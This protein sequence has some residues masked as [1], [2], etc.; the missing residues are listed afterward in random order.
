MVFR[1]GPHGQGYYQDLGADKGGTSGSAPVS[2]ASSERELDAA[3]VFALL[4]LSMQVAF[5][6]RDINAL[7]AALSAMPPEEAELCMSRCVSSG[8]WDPNGG[9]G[10][11]AGIEQEPSP[12]GESDE[13]RSC[14][15]SPGAAATSDSSPN[16]VEDEMQADVGAPKAR[17][18]AAESAVAAS[19]ANELFERGPYRPGSGGAA[20]DAA[21]TLKA[22]K[23]A[24]EPADT[25]AGVKASAGKAKAAVAVPKAVAASGGGVSSSSKPGVGKVHP[26]GGG[27]TSAQIAALTEQLDAANRTAAMER[28]GRQMVEQ[29]LDKTNVQV[30]R[31]LSKLDAAEAF[32][33]DEAKAMSAARIAQKRLQDE[34][35]QLRRLLSEAGTTTE[36][37]AAALEGASAGSGMDDEARHAFDAEKADPE[38]IEDMG[39]PPA[40][41][42]PDVVL[43][44]LPL[45]M[46]QAFDALDVAALHGALAALPP[47]EASEYMRRCVASGL[48]DPNGAGGRPDAQ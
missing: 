44:S 41:L 43:L 1:S 3:E 39:F 48:W 38:T 36:A 17:G 23:T 29:E 2:A 35:E 11:G 45:S 4:P 9:A 15:S 25:S 6:A 42:D 12:T 10:G 26:G 14:Q 13:P 21:K 40:S 18:A 8:L 22:P 34:N 24:N 46:Q 20:S 47:A 19:G 32:K 16:A 33:S 5:E 30:E 31:L 28:Q 37:I 7:D 27:A